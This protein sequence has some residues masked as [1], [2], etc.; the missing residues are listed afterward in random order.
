MGFQKK[1]LQIFRSIIK[2]IKNNDNFKL[3]FPKCIYWLNGAPGAGKDTHAK[4]IQKICCIKNNPVVVSSLLKT[5]QL[6]EIKDSASL[7][8]DSDV[9]KILFKHILFTNYT[10][11]VIIDGY[12][13]TKI[14]AQCVRLLY[15]YL[16]M[17]F[18]K[19]INKMQPIFRIVVLIV[20]EKVSINRQLM[21]G[22]KALIH[23][24][25]I[26]K[27]GKGILQEIRKTDISKKSA[28]IRYLIF[29]DNSYLS[30]N[31]LKKYFPYYEIDASKNIKLVKKE[32][33]QSLIN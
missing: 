10:K 2:E 31:S 11:G 22:K 24:Q 29:R 20:D 15:K 27:T 14:Q 33:F 26:L 3:K 16:K 32:I 18:T 30:L 1:T 17:L 4:F 6:Q 13:R 7:A 25:K 9:T 19:K 8:S 21:R 12:P 28:K 5:K 23:N